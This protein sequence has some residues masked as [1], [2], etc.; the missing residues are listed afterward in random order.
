MPFNAG[1]PLIIAHRG[2]SAIAPE[3]TLAAFRRAI[4]DGA[5]G[6][7]FDVRL[8]KDD[9][10]IIFHDEDL[11]R[12]GR[13]EGK[14]SDYT[15]AELQKTDIGT[16]FNLKNPHKADEKFSA[17]RIPTFV[18]L[19]EFL[20]GYKGVLYV[21]MKCGENDFAELV[22]AVCKIIVGSEVLPQI[23]LKSFEL[24]A[25]KL[26]KE[27]FPAIT[28][29]AL[30]EPKLRTILRGKFRLL[31]IAEAN[32]VDEIS[33]H[34]SLATQKMVEK[35]RAKNFPVTIWTADNPVW[36]KRAM[37]LGLNAI[38]TNNPARL[39]AKRREILQR[40]TSLV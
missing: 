8:T 19:L 13:R 30:F 39:L 34:Y 21:E 35:A 32:L 26:A 4:E 9:V 14:V 31:E 15:C 18:E 38:I 37:D 12:I 17:E 7:E 5:E 23:K 27:K 22:E 29:V 1:K 28:T 10:P 33:L 11:H 36:V 6:I 20:Q 16:W 40:A 2:A 25:I 24:S 3:N